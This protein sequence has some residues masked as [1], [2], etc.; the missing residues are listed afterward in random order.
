MEVKGLRTKRVPGMGK[1]WGERE[2]RGG[3]GALTARGQKPQ[4]ASPITLFMR[5]RIRDSAAESGAGGRRPAV[6]RDR[7]SY[8]DRAVRR[9]L[10][11][12][13]RGIARRRRRRRHG[14]PAV[15]L[16]YIRPGI[17]IVNLIKSTTLYAGEE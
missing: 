7:I 8:S 3:E 1:G 2:G 5:H 17:R 15:P 12:T 13:G 4:G 6:P 16:S 9:C 11:R 10:V 14:P